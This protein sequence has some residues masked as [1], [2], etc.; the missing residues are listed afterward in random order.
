MAMQFHD[1]Q[2]AIAERDIRS[3]LSDKDLRRDLQDHGA[4]WNKISQRPKEK[5]KFSFADKQ[6]LD[7]VREI[8]SKNVW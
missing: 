4:F 8:T 2:K 3:G 7:Y 5:I 6:Q 1:G